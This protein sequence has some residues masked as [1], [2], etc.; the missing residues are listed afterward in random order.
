MITRRNFLGTT[1]IIGAAG[2]AILG[3]QEF[4]SAANA[5][6]GGAPESPAPSGATGSTVGTYLAYPGW[7]RSGSAIISSCPAT[8]T[9]SS[10][11]R[12]S[13]IRA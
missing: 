1:A 7:S 12:S 2:T 8:S 9:S 4:K 13:R 10:S 6:A 11:T 3:G 5:A